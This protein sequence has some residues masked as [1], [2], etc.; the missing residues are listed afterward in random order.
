M[1]S[2]A[3]GSFTQQGQ[4]LLLVHWSN[5]CSMA[6]KH[7]DRQLALI[8]VSVGVGLKLLFT[9]D[10]T[11]IDPNLMLVRGDDATRPPAFSK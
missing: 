5:Q 4:V 1:V 2:G 6:G 11:C 3:S 9:L 10:E 8:S 7:G